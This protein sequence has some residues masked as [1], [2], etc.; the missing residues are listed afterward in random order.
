MCYTYLLLG[1]R[2]LHFS[3]QMFILPSIILVVVVV[4]VVD[5][6]K[7]RRLRLH[8]DQNFIYLVDTE[9][10]IFFLFMQI[11]FSLSNLN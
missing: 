1:F 2:C 10:F 7:H 6:D 8:N 9:L 3:G 5:S 4:I 11:V